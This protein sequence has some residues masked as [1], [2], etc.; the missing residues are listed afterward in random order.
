MSQLYKKGPF[1][2][3]GVGVLN[4]LMK[5]FRTGWIL[6]VGGNERLSGQGVFPVK[7]RPPRQ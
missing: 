3:V 7:G 2:I 6:V 5:V 4:S 1:R